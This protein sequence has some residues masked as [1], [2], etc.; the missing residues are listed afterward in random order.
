M[1]VLWGRDSNLKRTGLLVGKFDM[2]LKEVL[3]SCFV[4]VPWNFFHNNNN[5][6]TTHYL[7]PFKVFR[8]N[9]L[10]DTARAPAVDLLSLNALGGSKTAFITPILHE[11]SVSRS[12]NFFFF[13]LARSLVRRSSQSFIFASHPATPLPTLAGRGCHD[14]MSKPSPKKNLVEILLCI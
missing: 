14:V 4:G 1:A 6:K 13:I 3:R 12:P 8:L 9:T 5:F 7:S 2:N 11:T 10:K